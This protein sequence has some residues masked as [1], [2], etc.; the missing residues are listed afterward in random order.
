LYEFKI[1][2][3]LFFLGTEM[4][5]QRLK[6]PGLSSFNTANRKAIQQGAE[7]LAYVKQFKNFS[8]FWIL[9]AGHMVTIDL[10]NV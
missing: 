4:W 8:F 9:N 5:V 3:T 7:V 2:K 10:E 6:W 1:L